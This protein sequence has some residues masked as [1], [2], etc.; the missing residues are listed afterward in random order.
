MKEVNYYVA[1]DGS[2]FETR[3][4]CLNYES[5]LKET[6]VENFKK[7]IV[8]KGEGSVITNEASAFA[9]AE[10]AECWGYA[11]IVIKDETDYETVKKY[12]ALVSN[13]RAK[14]DCVFNKELLVGIGDIDRGTYKYNWFYCYG[15]IEEQI[16]KYKD[17]LMNFG[18]E[19]E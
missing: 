6:I 9:F 18:K 2:L 16:E 13:S 17:T 5:N 19:T 7:L 11:V 12:V 4:K 10:M 1:E 15:T 14:I 3:E 8:R